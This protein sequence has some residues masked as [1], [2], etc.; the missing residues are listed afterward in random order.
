MA[1]PP[2]ARKPEGKE[3]ALTRKIGPLPAWVW[4]AVAAAVILLYVVLHSKKSSASS[5]GG[6]GSGKGAGPSLVP[7]VVIHGARGRRGRRGKRG[8]SGSDDDDDDSDREG[9]EREWL[10]RKTGS[11]HPWTYLRKHDETIEVGPRGSRIVR[12]GKP[13]RDHDT[14]RDRDR[15]RRDKD[16]GGRPGDEDKAPKERAVR[17][18]PGAGP[19]KGQLVSFTTGGRGPTPS[20]AQVASRYNTAPDA[21]IE[22]ATGR[23]NPHG[24]MWRRYVAANDWQAPLPHGLDVTVLAQPA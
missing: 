4:I 24:A 6:S 23:G 15:K 13:V 1:E 3:N 18:V 10:E 8:K 11:E 7:P 20:L 16:T 19:V 12:D 14:D 2:A 17:G 9:P 22:E 21:I 5:K